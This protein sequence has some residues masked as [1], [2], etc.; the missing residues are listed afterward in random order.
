M[1]KLICTFVIYLAAM[2]MSLT[3]LAE[4]LVIK[5]KGVYPI[6][7]AWIAAL[8][9]NTVSILPANAVVEESMTVVTAEYQGGEP[10]KLTAVLLTKDNELVAPIFD[11]TDSITR[12]ILSLNDKLMLIDQQKEALI[13]TSQQLTD[14]INVER[15]R[16]GDIR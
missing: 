8:E 13:S 12:D 10:E 11:D 15:A 7:K 16:I 6:N 4:Q 9:H 5:L 14:A 3:C 2:C 1:S